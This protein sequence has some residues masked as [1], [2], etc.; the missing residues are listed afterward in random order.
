MFNNHTMSIITDLRQVGPEINDKDFMILAAIADPGS[1]PDHPNVY[2][3]SILM[4][5]FEILS[6]WANGD[7]YA[8]TTEYLAYLNTREPDEM[9]VVLLAALTKKN[10]VLYIPHD[11]YLV[12]GMQL[13]DHI[14]LTY[15]ISCITPIGQFN[16]DLS[17]MP[18][19]M[20]KFYVLDMMDAQ[21]YLELYPSNYVLPQFVIGKLMGD[22]KPFPY[23]ASMQEYEAYFNDLNART[24]PAQ[25]KMSM[26]SV[27]NDVGIL[28][29]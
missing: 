2:N 11:E 28:S 8:M 25:H 18:F 3:A 26:C 19:L 1:Y 12:F 6:A 4:P 14:R 23:A 21:T 5:P 10:V 13:V 9:L 15:G 24:N 27:V 7:P 16:I 17:R 20:S 22:F 29:R